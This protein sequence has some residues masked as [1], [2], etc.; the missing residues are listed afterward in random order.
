[1]I[2]ITPAVMSAMG[3]A[4][5]IPSIP[6]KSGKI[7]IS[8]SK[9]NICRVSE[10]KIPFLGFPIAVKKLEVMGCK[11]FKKVKNKNILK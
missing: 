6:R 8:G 4:Y 2:A 3:P 9:K 11:K 5:N 10:R 1:M 7:K